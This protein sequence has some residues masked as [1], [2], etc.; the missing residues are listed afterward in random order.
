V[1]I[2]VAAVI[3]ASYGLAK[4]IQFPT[5]T[6]AV[7]G[8][9]PPP[10]T[11]LETVRFNV[12]MLKCW[13]TSNTFTEMMA[14]EEGVFEIKTYTRTNTAVITYDPA[15]TSPE[16]LAERINA[17]VHNVETGET[18]KVFTVREIKD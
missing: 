18:M 1:P 13:G 10:G 5:Q 8:K 12:D 6:I 11:Q 17:P 2:A 3:L 4:T 14:K 7:K 15:R 9:T 16:R